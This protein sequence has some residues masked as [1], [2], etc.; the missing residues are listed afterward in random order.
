MNILPTHEEQYIFDLPSMLAG[1]KRQRDIALQQHRAASDL[2]KHERKKL[3]RA[4]RTAQEQKAYRR[5][6]GLRIVAIARDETSA[7]RTYL[8][9]QTPEADID[10]MEEESDSIL[11]EFLGLTPNGI[12]ELVVPLAT[13]ARRSVTDALQFLVRYELFSWTSLQNLAKGVAPSVATIMMHQSRLQGE[14]AERVYGVRQPSTSTR[15]AKY[16][17]ISRFRRA[18]NMPKGQFSVNDVPSVAEMRLKVL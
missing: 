3:V 18:W 6:V 2:L 5:A 15:W 4:V 12:N 7:L 13:K 11:R 14:L 9:D 8:R 17:W 1:L 10:T 16:K